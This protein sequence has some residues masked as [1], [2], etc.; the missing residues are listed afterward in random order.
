MSLPRLLEHTA[1]LL[2]IWR[3]NQPVPDQIDTSLAHLK[4]KRKSHSSSILVSSLFTRPH[5]KFR[6]LPLP[7]SR[8]RQVARPAAAQ[9]FRRDLKLRPAATPGPLQ[10][11]AEQV[12]RATAM[13]MVGMLRA[14]RGG[15]RTAHRPGRPHV[16]RH[17]HMPTSFHRKN[18]KSNP[19]L[20]II[21]CQIS[22]HS[23]YRT[24]SSRE[25][26]PVASGPESEASESDPGGTLRGSELGEHHKGRE[27][28]GYSYGGSK[29]DE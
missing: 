2:R 26:F 19:P 10:P 16:T 11:I 8:Q 7:R 9:Q 25:S 21:P 22:H 23:R 27:G 13:S 24:K 3:K 5:S 6:D 4:E 28:W 20:F 1:V 29:E 15:T 17:R 18:N 14:G 12:D